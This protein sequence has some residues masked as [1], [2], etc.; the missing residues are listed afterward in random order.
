MGVNDDA[1]GM[2]RAI[3]RR[4]FI[5]GA[6]ASIAGAS[7]AGCDERS[8]VQPA[9]RTSAEYPP[10]RSGLRGNHVGSFEVAHDLVWHGRQ[11]WGR[12]SD[13][14][15]DVYDLV[16][17]G[18][19]LSGLAAAYFYRMER[20][21]ARILIL[22]NHDDFGGHAKR[23]EFRI[24]GRL[25]IGYGGSQA[26]EEPGRYSEAAKALLRDLGVETGRFET[27]YDQDFYRRNGLASATYFDRATFGRDQMVRY[28][29]VDYS[30]FLP[31]GP[32]ALE[33]SDAVSQ[34]PIGDNARRELIALLE[35]RG[36]RFT[37]MSASQ[38]EEYLWNL[39]YRDFL[40]RHMS[41]TD[42]EVLA[43]YQGLTV[44][45]TASMEMTPAL[46]A[47]S[48]NGLPGL[49]A[50]A[51]ADYLQGDAPYIFHFPDGNASIARLLV[52]KLIPGAAAGR[53]M[54]DIVLAEMD[55]SSLDKPGQGVRLRLNSTVVRAEH[56]GTIE[57][58][59]F[60]SVTYV[61]RG[62]AYRVRARSCVMAGDNAM[63]P[64]ICPELPARQDDALASSIRAPILYTNVLL[65]NWRAW[66]KLGV[67]IF[68]SP[69]AF[70]ALSM[71]DFPV[72]MGGYTFSPG[73]DHPVIVH[74]E[75]FAKGTN[76]HA[77]PREQRLAG[78]RELLS[79]SFESIE[80]RTREQLAGAL[81]EGGFDPAADIAGLTVNRWAHG[82][83]Y[84][85]NP[86]SGDVYT[87]ENASNVIGRRS[88][89]R[90]A[91]ANSDAGAAAALDVAIDQAHRAIAEVLS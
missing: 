81:A 57:D 52:R 61:N 45:S 82:Y 35:A 75:H 87:E 67:G 30:V 65:T 58:A 24:D 78:R 48:Y 41:V 47:M 77:S 3:S 62:D 64:H 85:D 74:M 79:M 80:R 29:L 51:L 13:T 36:D 7:A 9:H 42:P 37:S 1:L 19:G 27:A 38:Q 73:P 31:I 39:S 90:I 86:L 88:L 10:G 4:D 49:N 44:D 68:A 50:T 26:L 55:Y 20:P 33:V 25:V 66:E 46:F 22:D 43:L 76:P 89:G 70:Y 71:L 5:N 69:G 32:T 11:D 54:D 59:E 18:A 15:A 16:V 34:M 21:G 12:M 8:N 28:P 6:I 14:D 2:N 23:N 91:I 56:A 84:E 53:T 83:S 40:Q 17:V 72:S 63:I 60:V